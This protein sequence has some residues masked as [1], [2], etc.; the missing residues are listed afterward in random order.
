MV[1]SCKGIGPDNCAGV[2]RFRDPGTGGI[3]VHLAFEAKDFP[4]C[5]FFRK[6]RREP[7]LSCKPFHVNLFM[8][9]AGRRGEG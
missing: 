4:C 3:A 9:K 7:H 6:N 5:A 8:A 1:K 2:T